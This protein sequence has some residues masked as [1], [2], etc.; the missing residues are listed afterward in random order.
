MASRAFSGWED[1]QKGLE[2]LAASIRPANSHSDQ[3]RK[4]LGI[5]DLI[6]KVSPSEYKTEKWVLIPEYATANP[7]CLQIPAPFL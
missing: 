6:V 2:T 1:L 4:S 7:A 3:R 5:K